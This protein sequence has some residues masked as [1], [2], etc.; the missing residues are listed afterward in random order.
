MP[1][2]ATRDQRIRSVKLEYNAV[3]H[4]NYA[5][6]E[7]SHFSPHMRAGRAD[8]AQF[9]ID[10]DTLADV[11]RVGRFRFVGGEPLLHPDL[12]DLVERV[13]VSGLA[14]SIEVVTNGSLLHKVSDDLLGAIDYLSVS[15]YDDPRCDDAKITRAEEACRRT[16]TTLKV[17]RVSEFRLMQLTTPTADTKLQSDIFRTCQIAHS[18]YCQTFADGYFFL[19]SRPLF[20]NAYLDQCGVGVPDLRLADGIPLHAPALRDRLERY[21]KRSDPL[22]SCRYCLGTVGQPIPWRAMT[23]EE[24]LQNEPLDRRAEESVSQPLL[25]YL[26]RW[27]RLERTLLRRLPRL[28]LAR[29]MQVVKEATMRAVSENDYRQRRPR[30]T[31]RSRITASTRLRSP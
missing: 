19:C 11:L 4:C 30:R 6:T 13:R 29:L 18:W 15:W 5:C 3:R 25:A 20:T 23:R 14:R 10:V 27:E 17:K 28:W 7:C 31:L 21:L 12:P 26:S 24:R 1:F 22:E 2:V 8:P 9:G 16:G